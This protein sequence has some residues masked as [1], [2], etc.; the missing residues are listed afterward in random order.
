MLQEKNKT[1]MIVMTAMM[2]G[3]IMVKAPGAK[4]QL[5]VALGMALHGATLDLA[6]KDALGSQH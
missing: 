3:L 6:V 4:V 2:M 1:T 5:G